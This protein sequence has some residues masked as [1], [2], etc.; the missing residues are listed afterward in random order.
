VRRSV[1]PNLARL[2]RPGWPE[3]DI[4]S[5]QRAWAEQARALAA[6]LPA[7]ELGEATR[8]LRALNPGGT[9]F[10]AVCH[11][12]LLPAAAEL[13]RARDGEGA[14]QAGYLMGLW[15]LRML[16]VGLDD[17][18]RAHGAR[19][20]GGASALL[21]AGASLAPTLEH[22]VVLRLFERAGWSVQCCGRQAEEDPC[23]AA[24]RSR[25][26]LAWFSVDDATDLRLLHGT[27]TEVRRASCNR[28]MR[29]LSGWQ[30][31][32][33]PPP[34]EALGADA[35]TEDATIAVILARQVL[36]LH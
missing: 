29:V 8:A 36:A 9:R 7:L 6:I 16:L 32:A 21:V 5:L 14:D 4:G 17:D 33:P 31:Q 20:R 2:Y 25:F 11:D 27:V 34:A 15:R 30:L 23:A 1:V 26:D 3:A 22:A 28:G 35:V 10:E 12:V 13:R 19:P 24:S 18:G